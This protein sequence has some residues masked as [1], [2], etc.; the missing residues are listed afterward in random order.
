MIDDAEQRGTG[1]LRGGRVVPGEAIALCLSNPWNC[2][3]KHEKHVKVNGVPYALLSMIG[4]KDGH[5]TTLSLRTRVCHI[6]ILVSDLCT[7]Y[8]LIWI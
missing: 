2:R 4:F 5:Y 3:L 7:V 6:F 1:F 8:H